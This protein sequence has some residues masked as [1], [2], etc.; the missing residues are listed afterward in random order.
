M[1][2]PSDLSNFLPPLRSKS[3]RGIK[4]RPGTAPPPDL[5]VTGLGKHNVVHMIYVGSKQ[6]RPEGKRYYLVVRLVKVH[7]ISTLVEL[8]QT[9]LIS[10]L[11]IRGQMV[12]AMLQDDDIIAGPFK[13]SL[14]CPVSRRA[15]QAKCTHI[16]CFDA[17]SWFSLMEQTT[18]WYTVLCPVCESVLDSR[19]LIID[20]FVAEILKSTPDS[21]DDVLVESDGQ[22]RTADGRYSSAGG[23]VMACPGQYEQIDSGTD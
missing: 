10:S 7:S 22:W 13:M 11:E 3:T 8:L 23:G 21:V 16:Q 6:G 12:G 9:R 5:G 19:E 1:Q 15:V 4:N 14:K 17:A 2:I 18:T 20:G